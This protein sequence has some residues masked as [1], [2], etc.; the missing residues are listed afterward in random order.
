MVFINCATSSKEQSSHMV[1]VMEDEG[2][3]GVGG[4]PS[5][6]GEQGAAVYMERGRS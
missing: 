3:G 4:C 1:A 6:E 5:G 2:G